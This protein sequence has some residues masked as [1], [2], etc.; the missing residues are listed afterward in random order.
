MNSRITRRKLASYAAAQLAAGES[1]PRLGQ[2][3]AAYLIEARRTGE[4]SLLIRDIETALAVE[5]GVVSLHVTAAHPLDAQLRAALAAFA[6]ED[7]HA[8]QTQIVSEMTDANLIGGVIMQTPT[9][10]FDSSIRTKL[11]Q[12]RSTI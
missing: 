7:E 6:T 12:L 8:S 2:Q 5:H 1:A 3:L 11:K 10:I 4:V 9:S